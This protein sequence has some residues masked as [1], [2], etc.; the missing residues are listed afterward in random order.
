M[1][2]GYNQDMTTSTATPTS[3]R[4]PRQT[5]LLTH[6]ARQ[7]YSDAQVEQ[8]L[9]K[10]TTKASASQAIDALLAAGARKPA[11]AQPARHPASTS[12]KASAKQIS[13]ALSLLRRTNWIDTDLGQVGGPAPTEADLRR[14]SRR[15]VSALIDSLR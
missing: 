3:D 5:E 11:A 8:A 15:E 1:H 7:F 10:Y 2:P 13:Y 14:M 9:G 6:L 4:T 12:G